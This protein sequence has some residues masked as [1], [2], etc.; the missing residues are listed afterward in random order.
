[1]QGERTLESYCYACKTYKVLPQKDA[2][3]M[4]VNNFYCFLHGL[5][6]EVELKLKPRLKSKDQT[7][8]HVLTQ[9][10]LLKSKSC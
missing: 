5:E 8:G 3:I 7:S 10:D 1:M 2:Q 9:A 6:L 4:S